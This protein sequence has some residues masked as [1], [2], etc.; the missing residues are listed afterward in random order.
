ME[1]TSLRRED[2]PAASNDVPG[3]S[4]SCPSCDHANPAGSRYCNQCG[5]PVHFEACGRCEAINLRG[6]ALCHKCGCSLPWSGDRNPAAAASA[7]GET[8]PSETPDIADPAPRRR[9]AGTRVA[10]I[11]LGLAAVAAST[12]IVTERPAPFHRAV[13]P[14]VQPPEP[15]NAPSISPAAAPGV[16]PAPPQVVSAPPSEVA[17]DFRSSDAAAAAAVAPP[18]AKSARTPKVKANASRSKSTTS[19]RKPPPRKPAAK[20]S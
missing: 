13:D 14:V 11:A 6:A 8:L 20:A 18:A 10:L 4:V 16:A 3:Q 17:R 1:N 7:A 9:Q 19:S 5:M 2:A 12:Y 15:V